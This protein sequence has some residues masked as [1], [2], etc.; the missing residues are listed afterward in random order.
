[1]IYSISEYMENHGNSNGF[2][3]QFKNTPTNLEIGGR[4]VV[5]PNDWKES[6]LEAVCIY[7]NVAVLVSVKGL[8]KGRKYLYHATGPATGWR[9]DGPVNPIYRLQ[10]MA[11]DRVTDEL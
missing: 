4:Y 10:I 7:D 1:M 3:A 11:D 6:T 2:Y 9:Y 8:D 5:C